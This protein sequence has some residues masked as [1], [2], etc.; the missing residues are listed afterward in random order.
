MAEL[1]DQEFLRYSRQLLLKEIGLDGQQKLAKAS[2]L[3]IGCGGLGSIAAL[4]L[5]AAG[6]GGLTLADGDSLEISNLQRQI[7]YETS[8]LKEQKSEAARSRLE[9]L[10]P[11]I[12]VNTLPHLQ[13][14]KL[15]QQVESHQLILD[16]S[17]NF[18]TRH[19]VNRASV[20]HRRPLIS[21]AAIGWRGQLTCIDP[22][23]HHGCY[24]CLHPD[25][26]EPLLSC[27]E[28]GVAGPVVGVI[29]SL[30]ALQA[31]KWIC[32]LPVPFGTTQLFD[33]MAGQW[34]RLT[35]PDTPHCPVCGEH[36]HAINH[37]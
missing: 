27:K 7:L 28:A 35:L 3:I 22:I 36:K 37:Q 30:Q 13:G 21:G 14:E 25:Q 34:Q 5:A 8:Q 19:Q 1:S 29:G 33:A 26:Q 6:V 9:A 18:A 2:V 4:Y 12:R 24:H 31:I 16:C 17:D 15:W 20:H 23:S 10:N 11:G 32:D